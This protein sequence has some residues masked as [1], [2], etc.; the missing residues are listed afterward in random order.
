MY[1]KVK[2]NPSTKSFVCKA[3]ALGCWFGYPIFSDVILTKFSVYNYKADAT[4]WAKFY[5]I[6]ISSLTYTW[7]LSTSTSNAWTTLTSTTSSIDLLPHL[8]IYPSLE[9]SIVR[10]TVRSSSL[11]STANKL[12][13][14]F[15][16][17]DLSTSCTLWLDAA[18]QSTIVYYTYDFKSPSFPVLLEPHQANFPYYAAQFNGTTNY[19]SYSPLTEELSNF[20]MSNTSVDFCA[21]AWILPSN[22]ATG[23]IISKDGVHGQSFSSYMIYLQNGGIIASVGNG[24][25]SNKNF[26]TPAGFQ[27]ST[28]NWSHIAFIRSN[29]VYYLFVNGTLQTTDTASFAPGNRTDQPLYV[30][31]S[32]TGKIS[33]LRITKGSA[34][35]PLVGFIPNPSE[36]FATNA[37]TMLLLQESPSFTNLGRPQ[38][39][40]MKQWIDKSP[41]NCSAIQT[42]HSY[43]PTHAPNSINGLSAITFNGTNQ[44]FNLNKTLSLASP[45]ANCF[46]VYTRPLISTVSISLANTVTPSNGSPYLHSN[47]NYIYGFNQGTTTSRVTTGSLIGAMSKSDLYLNRTQII[48]LQQVTTLEKQTDVSASS[49]A[50]SN[51]VSTVGAYDIYRHNGSIGEIGYVEG[52]LTEDQIKAIGQS[53]IN[54]WS[55]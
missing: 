46:F 24:L 13:S 35:Y 32:F 16:F 44:F 48:S 10:T 50:S 54:K 53:L 9:P 17:A 41:N 11:S 36:K 55:F 38:T 49:W 25:Y 4:N 23:T 28:T 42:T 7:E 43:I 45:S 37:S 18:D 22:S 1:L 14:L 40:G 52:P 19:L 27:L 39:T 30:G 3:S 34:V 47:N 21:E 29:N 51:S 6:P 31:T 33:K 12:V 8:N 2:G 26:A 5:K 20:D 15:T